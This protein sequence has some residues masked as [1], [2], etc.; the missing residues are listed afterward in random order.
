M[1]ND[2]ELLYLAKENNE[3][4]INILRKKYNSLLYKKA[5]KYSKRSSLSIKELVN[6]AEIYFY[7]AIDTYIDNNTF[8][9]YLNKV[10]DNNLTN[11]ISRYNNIK[12]K[13]LNES[14]SYEDN[15][16]I[17]IRLSSNKYNPETN[18][19]NEYDY[20]TLREKIINKLTW[21][22]ELIFVLK[23]QNYTAREISEI[24]DNNLRTVYNIIKIGGAHLYLRQSRYRH[25]VKSRGQCDGSVIRV[26]QVMSLLS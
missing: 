8:S 25:Q 23:E 5:T 7:K 22:E 1:Y 19:F 9:T 16:E 14:V 3:D 18:L 15:D 4:A 24:T 2:Y 13:V 6:E 11:Y 17:L 20:F 21:K 26:C 10:L 12:N